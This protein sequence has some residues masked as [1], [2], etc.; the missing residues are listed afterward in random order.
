MTPSYDESEGSA[1]SRRS[2]RTKKKCKCNRCDECQKDKND[3]EV[4]N[5]R[6]AVLFS[7]ELHPI[8][9]SI[10]CRFFPQTIR[11]LC[12]SMANHSVF[13]D[14]QFETSFIFGDTFGWHN[15]NR[16]KFH[17]RPEIRLNSSIILCASSTRI[18]QKSMIISASKNIYYFFLSPNHFNFYGFIK[19]Q[20]NWPNNQRT[21]I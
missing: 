12:R 5:N 19:W 2:S 3:D 1:I 7:L 21:P 11:F 10:S 20:L 18:E 17:W 4:M 6:A 9:S 16:N 14:D 8:R 15:N 13:R